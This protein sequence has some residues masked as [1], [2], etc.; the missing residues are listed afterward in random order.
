MRKL[1]IVADL[2]DE[3]QAVLDGL[4]HDVRTTPAKHDIISEGDRPDYVHLIVQGWAARYKILP[5]GSRQI[6]G[7]LI[8]GDF[9]D[10]HVTILGQMDHGILALTPCNVAYISADE[11]DRLMAESN[12]LAHVFWWTTLVDEG[13]LRSWIVNNGRRDAHERIAHLLCELHARMKMIGLVEDDRLD[14][15]LTQEEIADATGLTPVHTNR[16]LQ[17]LRGEGLI[18]LHGHVLTIADLFGLKRTA[19]FNANYLHIERR[20]R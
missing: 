15:P 18:E 5:D 12:K 17:R 19:G 14:F 3:E 11:L 9:C 4:C 7:V 8:P 10:L 6:L 16:T 13:V 1:K 2:N 20:I